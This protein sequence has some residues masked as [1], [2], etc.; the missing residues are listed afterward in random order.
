[1]ALLSGGGYGQ[2]T[3]VSKDHVMRKPE[4]LEF[5]QAAAITEAWLTAYQILKLGKIRAD[6]SVA[7]NGATGSV[8]SAAIQICSLLKAHPYVIVTSPEQ[9]PDCQKLG[10]KGGVSYKE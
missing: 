9:I 5:S 6:C 8:G 7:I 3:V 4:K 2:Y 10:A 1:M